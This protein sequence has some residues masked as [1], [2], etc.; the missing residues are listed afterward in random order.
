MKAQYKKLM[1][2]IRESDHLATEQIKYIKKISFGPV[3]WPIYCLFRR[4]YFAAIVL[5]SIRLFVEHSSLGQNMYVYY[6]FFGLYRVIQVLLVIYGRRVSWNICKWKDFQA[7]V[8]SEK[9]WNIVSLFFLLLLLYGFYKEI[10]MQ[11]IYPLKHP[12]F[13]ML[14]P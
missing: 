8:K 12:L 11:Y 13:R 10:Q 7:F 5:E 9:I 2:T 4:F 1:F 14:F 6:I 3:T